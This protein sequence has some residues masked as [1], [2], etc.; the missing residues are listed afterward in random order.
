M[1]IV[2]N[3]KLWEGHRVI[4]PEFREK[5]ICKCQDCRYYISI[6]GKEEVRQGCIE[7]YKELW[8][9][10]PEIIPVLVLLELLGEEGLREILNKGN[11]NAHACGY[12]KRKL[13]PKKTTRK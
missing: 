5:I 11:A 3:N 6:Q 1:S 8:T 9:R 13:A 2:N 4:L 12:F 7:K 10:P